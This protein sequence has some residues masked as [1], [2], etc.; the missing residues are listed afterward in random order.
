VNLPM[1]GLDRLALQKR[2][3]DIGRGAGDKPKD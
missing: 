1:T 2:L 3:D